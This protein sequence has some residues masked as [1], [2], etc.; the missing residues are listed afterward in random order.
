MDWDS[1]A[2]EDVIEALREVEWS[3]SPRS[4]A[5]FFSRFAFPRSFSKWM[6]RLKCNLY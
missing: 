5:E 6:S 1:V 3:A 4:L 2:A